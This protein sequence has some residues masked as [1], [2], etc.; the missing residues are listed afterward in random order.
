MGRAWWARQAVKAK[1]QRKLDGLISVEAAEPPPFTRGP[2]R[3]TGRAARGKAYENKLVKHLNRLKASGALAGDLY[4][5]P[6]FRFEDANGPGLAQPDA[7]LIEASHILVIEAKLKQTKAAIPQI[8][9]YGQL[10]STLFNLPW[11]GVQ[12]F[13][14][15]SEKRQDTTWIDS[16]DVVELSCGN[17][18]NWHWLT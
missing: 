1:R 9:L 14:F 12:V 13:Q 11:A 4:V 10:A 2:R 17:I 6:W 7:L 16:L 5:G 15:P 8:T 3:L 18:Y